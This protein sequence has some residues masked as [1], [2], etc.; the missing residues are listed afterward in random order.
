MTPRLLQ[1]LCDPVD[2]SDLTLIGPTYGSD[3]AIISG[4]LVSGHGCRYAI[5]DGIPRFV[6]A[7]PGSTASVDS[8]GEQWNWFNFD[9]FRINWLNHTVK[10]TFGSA[11]VFKGKIVV[12]CGA[13]SGM[14]T[15]WIAEAGAAHVVALE[16]SH[17]VDGV[18]KTNLRDVPNVDVVQ[19]S[20][21]HPPIR[22]GSVDGIVICHNVIQHTPSV[23]S[24][25]RALWRTVSPGGEF[26]FNCYPKNYKGV[27]R[28]ARFHLNSL[29]RTMLARCPFG[30]RLWYARL[31]SALRFVPLLGL[32]LEK[33]GFMV[34]GDVPP[35]PNRLRRAYLAGVLNTFD[36][37]G[38]HSYQH[39]KTDGE[40]IGL[41]TEL[42]PEPTR[43][44]NTD[45]YFL[46]P[47][48]F[49]IA[50]RLLK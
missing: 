45:R 10:N 50:L 42:Q 30:A 17:S 3:G 23:E 29:L 18:M 9:A 20:I 32:V 47:Q 2:K 24:T 22:D 31:M 5:R 21:D 35:G 46:R 4:T 26:V 14:Q 8:F 33:G 19:C 37:F 15:R 6:D 13:G 27:V 38:A 39:Y 44:L 43:V 41:V 49:G 25:A 16:L 7:D 11:D 34:R 40:I 48:P 12:D 36:W 1:I 28:R